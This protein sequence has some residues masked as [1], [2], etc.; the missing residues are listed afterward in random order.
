MLPLDVEI[1]ALKLFVEAHQ[2]PVNNYKSR[3][4]AL[5]I[6]QLDRESAF[7]HYESMQLKRQEKENEK[8]KNKDIKKRD[9][10]LKY[11]SKLDSTFHT[12]FQT[13]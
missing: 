10:V 9:L 3:L 4:N 11:E 1:P 6:I 7:E 13:K 12:V 2:E 8:V 5:Q